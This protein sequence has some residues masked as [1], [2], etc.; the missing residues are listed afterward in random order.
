MHPSPG[1][2][3]RGGSSGSAGLSCGGACLPPVPVSWT[4]RIVS[5][6]M[7]CGERIHVVFLLPLL[8]KTFTELTESLFVFFY[9]A[10]KYSFI[11]K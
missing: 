10:P 11:L 1:A 9:F 8:F 2:L 6:K 7:D 3:V 5:R 4:S